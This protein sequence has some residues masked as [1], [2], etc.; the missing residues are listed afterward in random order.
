M[1]HFQGQICG[2][3]TLSVTLGLAYGLVRSSSFPKLTTV[4]AKRNSVLRLYVTAIAS[5]IA[6]ALV[7]TSTIRQYLPTGH[8]MAAIIALISGTMAASLAFPY[9][10]I[11]AMVASTMF[12]ENKSVCLSFLDGLGYLL[13]APTWATTSK[14]VKSHG[15]TAAWSLLALIFAMSGII[16]VKVL[17]PVLEEQE[18]Q[19]IASQGNKKRG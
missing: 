13:V 8:A 10:Q 4:E 3:L 17:P 5:A 11:P 12:G 9:Y 6:L 7:S 18:R 19:A 14:I 2:G 15:W 16:M 1:L